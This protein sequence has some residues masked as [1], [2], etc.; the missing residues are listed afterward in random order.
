MLFECFEVEEVK[1]TNLKRREEISRFLKSCQLAFEQ[2]IEYSL[3]LS[4]NDEIIAT[5]SYSNSI[6]K[7]IAISKEYQGYGISEYIVSR[8][9]NRM[10]L[11][12]RTHF[13]LVTGLANKIIFE[14]LG[15]GMIAKGKLPFILMEYPRGTVDTY[16]NTLGEDAKGKI[17]AVVMNCNPFTLGHQHL[18][19]YAAKQCDLLHVFIVSEDQSVFPAKVRYR[20]V[21]EGTRHLKNVR[22]HTTGEYMISRATFPSYFLKEQ[23]EGSRLHAEI[24]VDFFI[25]YV[26]PKLGINKRF[27]GEEP[28][29]KTTLLYNQVMKEQFNI[30]N[31][32]FEEISRL[33]MGD[34]YVSASLV[35]E[36]IRQ[37]QMSKVKS[38]VP[39][40][41]YS[42]L[43]ST[44][45]KNIITQIKQMSQT[46]T[47][48]V[49]H[50]SCTTS[51]GWNYGV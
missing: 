49:K 7:C 43:I 2:D 44:E 3:V 41:T 6:I 32:E 22:M 4:I 12:G 39:E 16:V 17:G 45:S 20:L 18:I 46:N 5:G 26:V 14:G 13:F 36:L 23:S 10:F 9:M 34:Q 51:N 29:C 37:D 30:E 27:V 40:T 48:R 15:F 50:E 33:K 21:E 42:F 19:E 35:R 28:Y 25:R 1:E 8:L 38:F 31:I 11:L 47:R 24:D